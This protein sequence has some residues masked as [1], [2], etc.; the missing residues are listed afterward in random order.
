MKPRGDAKA[1]VHHANSD[2][3]VYDEKAEL[4]QYGQLTEYA[5][6]KWGEL[7]PE[8]FAA[9]CLQTRWFAGISTCSPVVLA[10]LQKAA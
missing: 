5:M 4:Q 9:L 1:V 10:P 7:M 2:V 8:V 3:Y 6:G